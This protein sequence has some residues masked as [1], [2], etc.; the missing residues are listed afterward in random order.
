MAPFSYARRAIL[1]SF[2]W[3][4]LMAPFYGMCVPGFTL[5]STSEY[6]DYIVLKSDIYF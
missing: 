6:A 5:F 3:Y 1:W 4:H 2:L